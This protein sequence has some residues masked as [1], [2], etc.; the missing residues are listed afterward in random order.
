[1]ILQRLHVPPMP[2]ITVNL[3][4]H[5][6]SIEIECGLLSRLGERVRK[7]GSAARVLLAVDS[8]I[9]NTHGLAASQSLQHAGLDVHQHRLVA[10]EKHKS[11]E[12]VRQLYE[13]ML[14]AR[15]ERN[16]AVIALGG[17][18]VGDIAGFAAATYMRGVPFVQVPTTLLAMVDA[19]IG[20]K[21]GVNFAVPVGPGAPGAPLVKNLIGAFWQPRAVFIDPAVLT[22]LDDRHFRCGL[23]ECI[24]HGLI[25]DAQLLNFIDQNAA[26][27]L[28]KDLAILTDLIARSA[29]IK[30]AIVAEDERETTG[31]RALLNLGHTF[32]HAIEPMPELGLE[33]GEAV[34][35][36]LIAAMRCAVETKRMSET[37]ANKVRALIA[38][39]GLPTRISKPVPMARILTAMW[40]DKKVA[41][42]KLRLILPMGLGNAALGDDVP[43][44]VVKAALKEIGA[45]D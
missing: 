32:G 15:L 21:T 40:Y 38:K 3:A 8:N 26:Q 23:A 19:S 33:H 24:K 13:A 16:S 44:Q 34:A 28:A 5:S 12:T 31:R 39:L 2:Q 4:E 14:R 1:M 18:I 7:I 29:R 30:A 17:G 42:D 45:V 41:H 6:Y 10:D 11:L 20:G 27:I 35:I 36:G 25:A 43:E 9:A 22:T 37:D